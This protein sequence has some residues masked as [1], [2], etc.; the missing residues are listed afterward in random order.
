MRAVTL[1]RG[2]RRPCRIPKPLS[3]KGFGIF[4]LSNSFL[5]LEA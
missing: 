5:I 1:L 2:A 3:D 4:R